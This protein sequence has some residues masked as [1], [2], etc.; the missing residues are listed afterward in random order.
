MSHLFAPFEIG[1]M[2]LPNRIIIAPMCQYSAVEGSATDWHMIHL[3]HLALSGAALLI[4]EATAVCAEGRITSADLGLYNDHNAAALAR[5]IA[6]IRAYSPIRLA[7][8]LAHA[9]RKASVRLPWQG[10]AQVAPD[11]PG[12]WKTQ[13]PS[14]VPFNPGDDAP[15]ALDA[16]G[17]ARVREYF[18]AAARRAATLGFEGIEVHAAHGYLLHQFLSPIAN[19]RGDEYGGPL[20]NRLRFPLEIF[21]SVRRAFPAERPVWVRVS[22]SDWVPGGW[23][24]EDTLAFAEALKAR[25]CA[26]IHVSSGGLSP[27]QKIATG[28]GYQVPFAGRI[29][30]AT[31]MPTIAVG[32]I[33]EAAQAEAI[34][35]GGEADAIAVARAALYDPRWPWHAA[36]ELGATVVAPEQYLRSQ[37]G[38]YKTLLRAAAP[39]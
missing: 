19:Q 26:A 30:A 21:E 28:P 39:R 35:A 3:G 11:L 38:K 31:G 7:L 29:K 13:A 12:G 4:V 10:G 6:A 9:G 23:D 33:T 27:L 32:L 17:M 14:P 36:A 16:K 37:P 22:A 8:Q 5:V 34:L 2:S 15:A 24:I 18:A 25:G 1:G 20:K